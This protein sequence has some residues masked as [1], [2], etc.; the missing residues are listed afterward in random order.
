MHSLLAGSCSTC[1][2]KEHTG[3][4]MRLTSR[5]QQIQNIDSAW[6]VPV[7]AWLQ[8]SLE[9]MGTTPPPTPPCRSLIRDKDQFSGEKLVAWE[10]LWMAAVFRWVSIMGMCS[11]RS[12][13][14]SLWQEGRLGMRVEG[15]ELTG[16]CWE[17]S[18][19]GP[20]WLWLRSCSTAW[21]FGSRG[22]RP[23]RTERERRKVQLMIKMRCYVMNRSNRMVRT[24]NT[25]P[26]LP[27]SLNTLSSFVAFMMNSGYPT[28]LYIASACKGGI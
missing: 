7:P 16:F 20:L 15:G 2:Q 25:A 11:R 5:S 1:K 10:H 18:S 28:M 4:H 19:A 22:L 12:V 27:T 6:S 8:I 14:P 23:P 9:G 24:H 17:F 26:C 3:H 21:H 13:Q